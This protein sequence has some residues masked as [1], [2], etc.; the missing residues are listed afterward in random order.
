[1][2]PLP[3][4]LR[5]LFL[6]AL[7]SVAAGG[8]ARGQEVVAVLS[9]QTRPYQEA[10]AGF[11][12][13]FG[14][15]TTS[16]TLPEAPRF[17]PETRVVVTFGGGALERRP[18]ARA[19]LIY[20]LA[21]G[22]VLG[23]KEHEGPRVRVPMV[24]DPAFLLS[25]LKALQ[26]GLRRLAVLWSSEAFAPYVRGLEEAARPLGLEVAAS[27]VRASGELPKRLRALAQA[28]ALWLPPDPLL[29]NAENITALR[30]FSR[31]NRLPLYVPTESLLELGGAA[32]V[33]I[34]FREMGRAAG[35]AARKAA[36]GEAVEGVVVPA[37]AETIVAQ[38]EAAR[39]GLSL[40]PAELGQA[41][42]LLP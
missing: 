24:P 18:P 9:A 31:A 35:R 28:E 39:S 16:F 1:M 37:R 21:P 33:T 11:R 7:A 8:A 40:S 42:R 36:A 23:P 12:E 6:A 32:A 34:S 38:G 4:L 10:F 19:T 17:A 13:T 3:R 25:R 5:R 29:L 15:S 41:D 26:P 14:P 2:D 22:T 30:D 27:R 20:A